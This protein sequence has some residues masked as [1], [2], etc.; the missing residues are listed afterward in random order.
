MIDGELGMGSIHMALGVLIGKTGVVH[1]H[2]HGHVLKFT[3]PVGHTEGTHVVALRK[4]QLHRHAAE[5][6]QLEGMGLDS[7]PL[8]R[9]SGASGQEFPAALDFHQAE[10]TGPHGRQ[11]LQVAEGRHTEPCSAHR[12]EKSGT[13][14]LIVLGAFGGVF[15]SVMYF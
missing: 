12:I 9:L 4:E 14:G 1:P 8:G 6:L 5:F 11:A 10:A 13:D 15:N 3:V 2:L 7:P